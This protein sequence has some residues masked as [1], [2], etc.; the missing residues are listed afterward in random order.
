MTPASTAEAAAAVIATRCAACGNRSPLLVTRIT[1]W[2]RLFNTHHKASRFSNSKCIRET[3]FEYASRL[4]VSFP[5]DKFVSFTVEALFNLFHV[6]SCFIP[7]NQSDSTKSPGFSEPLKHHCF[8][9]F[10]LTADRDSR[11]GLKV[12]GAPGQNVAWAPPSPSYMK[13]QFFVQE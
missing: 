4:I 6:T 11:T 3:T 5:N 9:R 7:R 10:G 12:I 1:R 13:M 2:P 8:Q